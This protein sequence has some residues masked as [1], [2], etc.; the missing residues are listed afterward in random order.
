MNK[1]DS[2]VM[3]GSDDEF[4]SPSLDVNADNEDGENSNNK[5]GKKKILRSKSIIKD[6][7]DKHQEKIDKSTVE[8]R[9]AAQTCNSV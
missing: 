6:D 3:L 7:F 4:K 1:I 9:Y 2:G 5:D 8:S